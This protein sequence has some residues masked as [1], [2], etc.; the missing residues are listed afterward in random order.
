MVALDTLHLTPEFVTAFRTLGKQVGYSKLGRA[1]AYTKVPP[2]VM[3]THG[4]T[5]YKPK[6]SRNG[7][8]GK[9]QWFCRGNGRKHT[10]VCYTVCQACLKEPDH[11]FT[12]DGKGPMRYSMLLSRQVAKDVG[13]RKL[14]EIAD[15]LPKRECCGSPMGVMP[16]S[17]DPRRWRY[18]CAVNPKHQEDT[19]IN[20]A[21][22]P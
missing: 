22:S 12:H 7:R 18:Q 13:V 3:N 20:I 16:D 4:P 6:V 8:K 21:C 19:E 1:I 9:H 5:A 2:A 11:R 15:A 17:L 10:C 14:Q